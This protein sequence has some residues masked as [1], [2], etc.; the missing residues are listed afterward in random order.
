MQF[1]DNQKNTKLA[2][3]DAKRVA[4]MEAKMLESQQ[5][6]TPPSTPTKPPT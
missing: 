6:E 5:S 2:K 3:A 1:I 4:E